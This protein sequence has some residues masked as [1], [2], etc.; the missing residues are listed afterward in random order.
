MADYIYLMETRLSLAQQ[1]ALAAVRSAAREHDTTVFLTGG[2]VR[3]LTGGGSIRDLDVTVQGEAPKLRKSLEKLGAT[4]VGE[5]AAA[6]TLYLV[7]PGGIRLELST[8][9]SVT[10]PKPGKPK[11]EPA[12]IT[13]D[14]RQRDFTAN[15]MAISLNDGSFGLLMDPLNGVADI[16]NRELRLVSNYGFIE[17]P[18]RLIRAARLSSRLGWQM[19]ARTATRYQAAKDEGYISAL[20]AWS[21]GYE[22]E[23]LFHEEDPVRIIRALENEGWM[24]HLYPSL[25][26]AKANVAALAELHD[27]QG[28]LQ[29]Q[30]ILAQ[31]AA[32]SFPLVTAKMPAPDVI[33]LKAMFARPGFAAE[34]NSLEARTKDFN[35][36]FS[37]KE[38]TQPSSVWK[39]LHASEPNVV[40][41][42]AYSAKGAAVQAKLMTFLVDSPTARQRIPYQMMQEMRIVPDL[43]IYSELMDKLFFELMDGKL[44]TPEEMK[45][46]L[47]PFSPPAPPPPI[48]LRRARAKKEAKPS[49]AKA[50][51][52]AAAEALSVAAQEEAAGVTTGLMDKGTLTGPNRG[53]EPT[54]ATPL[55]GKVA[56]EA[57]R[58]AIKDVAV[59]A[60]PTPVAAK[61]AK[62]VP[63][64]TV[65]A[66]AVPV[67]IVA[68]KAVP[69]KVVAKAKPVPVK[70]ATPAKAAPPAKKKPAVK[71]AAKPAAK[72]AVVKTVAKKAAVKVVAKKVVAKKV[73]T[74][75]AATKKTA[76]V[77]KV[78]AKKVV[79]KKVIAKKSAPAKKTVAKKV[80]APAKKT[81]AKKAPAKKVVAKKA[82]TA[83]AIKK[84]VPAGR[85]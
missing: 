11:Y 49:R 84:A 76:P 85:R 33:K 1:N 46:Y 54:V 14:L 15:A 53:T 38:I 55:V 16:E 22:L 17:D 4:V 42:L 43:P 79:A 70:K 9:L 57:K 27:R 5:N 35:T 18:A 52:A 51:K 71:T 67:R 6:L 83:K 37:A 58:K 12:S 31:S 64:T 73:A 8:A 10:F 60:K 20:G 80:A 25:S 62:A 23:E 24:T 69:A 30:G 82:A 77:K 48:N 65:V 78:A 63:V 81:A 50:K 47:E 74:V 2:A 26:S 75:K 36:R 39:M 72:K 40:L 59:V 28:Q 32:I 29:T 7:F 68:A 13:E 61:A 56:P 34:I 21:K 66:K 41:S 3:D 44:T 19:E 45:A